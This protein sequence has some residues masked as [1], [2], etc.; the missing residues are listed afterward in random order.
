MCP[1]GPSIAPAHFHTPPIHSN[2]RLPLS[3]LSRL[4]SILNQHAAV[5]SLAV[6]LGTHAGC[7][8]AVANTH[9]QRSQLPC[10]RT[11]ASP[12]EALRRC[13]KP[14]ALTVLSCSCT[15]SSSADSRATSSV[16]FFTSS[17]AAA[18]SAT[19]EQHRQCCYYSDR[20]VPS[21]A[22]PVPP[23]RAEHLRGCRGQTT[24]VAACRLMPKA[25]VR[26]RQTSCS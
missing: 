3:K 9:G 25:A 15:V 12:A 18:A 17:V 24:T 4:S 7:I 2:K 23:V 19:A 13:G 8:D 10:K 11:A 22:A 26:S 5:G 14:L 6:A 20:N 16:S 21:P 1:A